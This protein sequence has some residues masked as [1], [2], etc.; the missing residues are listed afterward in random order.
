MLSYRDMD[1]PYLCL[2]SPYYGRSRLDQAPV[3]PAMVSVRT[4]NDAGN[5]WWEFI[6]FQTTAY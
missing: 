4:L 1:N 5:E 6:M 3:Q 2:S